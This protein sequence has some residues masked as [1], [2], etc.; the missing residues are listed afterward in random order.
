MMHGHE[1]SKR[2]VR[3]NPPMGRA[4]G[5]P[6]CPIGA[7]VSRQCMSHRCGERVQDLDATSADLPY[8]ARSRLAPPIDTLPRGIKAP[9]C[10]RH[11]S[12]GQVTR[13]LAPHRLDGISSLNR[14]PA[15]G[16][17]GEGSGGHPTRDAGGRG[18]EGKQQIRTPV[19]ID[20]FYSN[21]H[22]HG[23][24]SSG[25]K[26]DGNRLHGSG[27]KGVCCE[28]GDGD[29]P[30][31]LRVDGGGVATGLDVNRD[32]DRCRSEFKDLVG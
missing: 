29:F 30:I 15:E 20:I 14:L 24:G 13:L 10:G 31:A 22:G 17:S 25:A 12:W 8:N 5:P 7:R 23:L 32:R 11:A 3:V 18:V 19:T 6:I 9:R 21:L 26:A 28:D 16:L 27:I 4:S 1:Y 2:I